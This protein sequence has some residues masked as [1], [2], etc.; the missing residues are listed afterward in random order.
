MNL[1]VGERRVGAD[2]AIVDEGAAADRVGPAGDRDV[3]ILEP[4]VPSAMTDAQLRD[5][6]RAPGDRVLVA[7]AARLRVVQ[8]PEPVVDLFHIV[9]R[10]L[11]GL[12][13]RVIHHAVAL[14]VESSGR[15]GKLPGDDREAHEGG[16]NQGSH[17]ACVPGS[18]RG[19]PLRGGA[20][21]GRGH[22]SRRKR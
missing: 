4:A 7:L 22:R 16:G 12:V 8:R 20:R 9:E 10:R 13:G 14:V 6:T 17:G 18:A 3:G 5:L 15:V 19:A 1:R 2:G 11:I 21:L